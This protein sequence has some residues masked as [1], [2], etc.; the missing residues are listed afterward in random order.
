MREPASFVVLLPREMVS[1]RDWI[2]Y[3][4]TKTFTSERAYS[5]YLSVLVESGRVV[6]RT[7]PR[8]A[9]VS[10]SN[11]VRW[12]NAQEQGQRPAQRTNT[13]SSLLPPAN[14]VS[15]PLASRIVNLAIYFRRLCADRVQFEDEMHKKTVLI[16]LQRFALEY[17][18]SAT[19]DHAAESEK[20]RRLAAGRAKRAPAAR[21]AARPALPGLTSSNTSV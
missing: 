21:S 9:V 5:A 8:C 7:N 4:G 20:S 17:I 2:K 19:L 10:P 6:D 15:S 11:P 3:S 16:D 1:A 18:T 12:G 14:L 13:G